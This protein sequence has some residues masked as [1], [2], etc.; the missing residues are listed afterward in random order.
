MSPPRPGAW[1]RALGLRSSDA[2]VFVWLGLTYMLLNAGANLAWLALTGRFIER[3]GAHRMPMVYIATN[4][5]TIGM[6]LSMATRSSPARMRL[7]FL[8]WVGFSSAGLILLVLGDTGRDAAAISIA[9]VVAW[10]YTIVVEQEFWSFTGSFLPLRLANRLSPGIEA[11]GTCGRLLGALLAMDPLA[12]HSISRLLLTAAALG[13][14]S[15]PVIFRA[16]A[17]AGL[18]PEAASLGSGEPSAGAGDPAD[19]P[20]PSLREVVGFLVAHPLMVR[21]AVISFVA[22]VALATTDYP[23]AVTARQ[24]YKDEEA[25]AG[26][27]GLFN[28]VSS[29]IAVLIQL[30][31][32]GWFLRVL[33]LQANLSILPGALGLCGAL[34]VLRPGFGIAMAVRFL[35]RSMIRVMHTPACRILVSP[36]PPRYIPGARSLAYRV[37]L[38]L[39]FITAGV[40]MQLPTRGGP[41]LWMVFA[42]LALGG[43]AGV[44]AAWRIDTVYLDALLAI[45]RR[46][47]QPE[48]TP[49]DAAYGGGAV[50]RLPVAVEVL[51]A[52]PSPAF[53]ELVRRAVREGGAESIQGRVIEGLRQA[54]EPA[55]LRGLEMLMR[56]HLPGDLSRGLASALLRSG[57]E[58]VLIRAARAVGALGDSFHVPELRG[59]LEGEGRPVPWG[60]RPRIVGALLRVASTPED[61]RFGLRELKRLLA[62]KE[63]TVRARAVAVLGGFGLGL[64]MPD[65]L[66]ALDDPDREVALEAARALGRARFPGAL[67]RL[68]EARE[69]TTDPD[70]QGELAKAAGRIQNRLLDELSTLLESMR[71]RE[72]RRLAQSIEEVGGGPMLALFVKALQVERAPA[73]AALVRSLR[74][75]DEEGFAL[76]LGRC[77]ETT[78]AENPRVGRLWPLLAYAWSCAFPVSHPVIRLVGRIFEPER[79]RELHAF[80]RWSL[81]PLDAATVPL[82]TLGERLEVAVEL[83]GIAAGRVEAFRTAFQAIRLGQGRE[84]AA[85]LELVEAGLGHP[86]L[87]VA[88]VRRLE[89]YRQRLWEERGTVGGP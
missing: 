6:F 25:L 29:L 60:A 55:A 49:E 15:I 69:R 16:E 78:S 62:A 68:L 65:L 64:F 48:L 87:K 72:R 75:I 89:T 58:A 36:I 56:S 79:A 61:L 13:L 3:V 85:A 37:A 57:N 11:W 82:E 44:L 10:L 28:A 20:P 7:G 50:G 4:V 14:A 21:L 38:S 8:G 2:Q 23:L 40:L 19:P 54:G 41:P 83:A 17:L 67:P 47:D 45:A 66:R 76:V 1:L 39:G 26:F 84:A 86:R 73:R 42:G 53:V 27:F 63:P 12:W 9:F 77:L 35:Q 34:G 80:L 71:D 43:T 18:H 59:R 51:L 52:S 31:G 81:R 5:L 33:S 24:V 46:R 22:G 30:V 74:E 88:L 70:L 32:A